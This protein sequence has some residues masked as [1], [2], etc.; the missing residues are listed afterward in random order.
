MRTR[1]RG[2]SLVE[3][4]LLAPLL[5]ALLFGIIDL[6]YYIWGYVTVFNAARSASESAAMLPPYTETLAQQAV[7]PTLYLEDPCL[8]T[9]FEQARDKTGQFQIDPQRVR[10]RYLPAPA[11]SEV[12]QLGRPI[13]VIVEHD[14]EPLTP[15]VSF[16]AG[17]LGGGTGVMNVTAISQRSIESL[18]SN[19]NP[20][21]TQRGGIAC[22]RWPD[23]F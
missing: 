20:A 22:K 5:F 1:K 10:V 21:Y 14:I 19:P 18:G 11:G 3:M 7:D 17:S 6:S 4:A 2:Q 15:L 23:D 16:F 13:E 8:R 9:I 12:R